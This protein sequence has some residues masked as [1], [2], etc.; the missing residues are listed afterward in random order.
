MSDLIILTPCKTGVIFFDNLLI[1]MY[2]VLIV[3]LIE[4][5]IVVTIAIKNRKY[6]LCDENARF[7]LGILVNPIESGWTPV[8][9]SY[10]AALAVNPDFGKWLI[11]A[12][13]V[14]DIIDPKFQFNSTDFDAEPL[15]PSLPDDGIINPLVTIIDTK[16]YNYLPDVPKSPYAQFLSQKN[17]G[18]YY[19]RE[20]FCDHRKADLY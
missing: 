14:S 17:D 9:V 18:K 10:N 11:D 19:L 20:E 2:K 7:Y 5:K 15:F 4:A 1:V 16:I 3:H 8:E 6:F 13:I 12:P